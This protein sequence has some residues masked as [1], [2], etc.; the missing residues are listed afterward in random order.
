MFMQTDDSKWRLFPNGPYYSLLASK[1]GM[2]DTTEHGM[3]SK[4]EGLF[5]C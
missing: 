4:L 2:V 1:G 5:Y 3:I